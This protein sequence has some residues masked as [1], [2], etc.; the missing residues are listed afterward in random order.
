[1]NK[2][3]TNYYNLLLQPNGG[4]VGIGAVSP[5]AKLD[6]Q[7]TNDNGLNVKNSGSSHAS[8]Y[9]DGKQYSYLRFRASGAEKFRLQSSPTGDLSFRPSGGGHVIDIKY[10]G[11]VGIG[12]VSPK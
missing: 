12:T 2:A 5:G 8:V 10:N 7:F 11:N 4:N 9:I 3:T 1:M 6:V